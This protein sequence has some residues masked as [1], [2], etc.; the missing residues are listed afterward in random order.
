[1]QPEQ[2]VYAP[3]VAE[4]PG[5]GQV[6]TIPSEKVIAFVNRGQGQMKG[7]ANWIVGHEF[8]SNVGPDDLFNR[9][10]DGDGRKREGHLQGVI[11]VGQAPLIQF[12]KHGDTGHDIKAMALGVPPFP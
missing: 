1:M 3:D 8:V 4:L 6:T 11:A 9:F 2:S 5:F 10:V 7:I 12:R